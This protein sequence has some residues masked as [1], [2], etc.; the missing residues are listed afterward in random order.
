LW[1]AAKLK[2]EVSRELETAFANYGRALEAWVRRSL[3]ELQERFDAK[4]DAY[5][6]QLA[7]LTEWKSLPPAQRVQI[8]GHL[9]ELE[10]MAEASRGVPEAP[11]A[12]LGSS[13]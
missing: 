10:A 1:V 7:R 13:V 3:G 12:A 4:A 6:A 5:R 8:E 2:A 11:R 9:K